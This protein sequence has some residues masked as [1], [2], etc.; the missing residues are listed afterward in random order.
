MLLCCLLL[1]ICRPA[2]LMLQFETFEEP[3]GT[4][5]GLRLQV[6]V[7]CALTLAV[8][9]LLLMVQR[10]LLLPGAVREVALV[11]GKGL[12]VLASCWHASGR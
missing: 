1:A 6:V 9:Q 4:P 11:L 2:A 12:R 10:L 8:M 5:A 7:K 3:R